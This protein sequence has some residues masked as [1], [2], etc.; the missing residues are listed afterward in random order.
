MFYGKANTKG[1]ADG[2]FF[3][4]HPNKDGWIRDGDFCMIS[5]NEDDCLRFVDCPDKVVEHVRTVIKAHKGGSWIGR[6]STHFHTV[7]LK[8]DGNLMTVDRDCKY[9][10]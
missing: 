1:T 8:L 10:F 6:Q 5:L 2:I 3:I 7:Q 9:C 4:H